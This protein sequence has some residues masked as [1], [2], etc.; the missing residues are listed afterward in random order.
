MRIRGILVTAVLAILAGCAPPPPAAGRAAPAASAACT[1]LAPA[2]V[3]PL[4][5]SAGW[6]LEGGVRR[7]GDELVFTG[8][9]SGIVTA[10]VALPPAL[11]GTWYLVADFAATGVRTGSAHWHVPKQRLVEPGPPEQRV[12]GGLPLR[13]DHPWRPCALVWKREGTGPACVQAWMERCSGIWRLRNIRL[14]RAA[15]PAA[16]APWEEPAA[17][18]CILDLAGARRVPSLSVALVEW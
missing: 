7:A 1:A 12:V 11:T 4:P 2:E 16:S 6:V 8:D 17:P 3:I 10:E 13:G 18:R 15:P 5:A 14:Q 9:P